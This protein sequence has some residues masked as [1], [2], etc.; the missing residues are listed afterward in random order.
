MGSAIA[1]HLA[2]T[3]VKT[4]L[5]DIVPPNLTDKERDQ[6]KARSRFAEA[7]IEKA[8]KAKPAAFYDPEAARLVQT[9]NLE[10]HLSRLAE[11]DLV[12]EAI[13]E[14]LSIKQ[15]LFEKIAPGQRP[16]ARPGQP[17]GADPAT[18]GR[19]NVSD[20]TVGY[21]LRMDNS[22]HDRR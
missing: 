19:G 18:V 20:S 7:G 16:A 8:L 3:G 5:L 2:G 21:S 11:C 12:I 4:D 6:P 15:K 9:G 10:D 13:V 14:D 1:A 17:P 22:V